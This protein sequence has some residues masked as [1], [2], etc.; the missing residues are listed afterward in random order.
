ML[1]T[2]LSG[3][4]YLAAQRVHRRDGRV[5][6]GDR[7]GQPHLARVSGAARRRQLEEAGEDENVGASVPGG[8]QPALLSLD[9]PRPRRRRCGSRVPVRSLG[10]SARRPSRGHEPPVWSRSMQWSLP[11]PPV[12]FRV[13]G[14]LRLKLCVHERAW[15]R[16]R[17]TRGFQ[18]RVR[19]KKIKGDHRETRNALFA[20]IHCVCGVLARCGCCCQRRAAR[21]H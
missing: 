6:I 16:P 8:G 17:R 19:S 11:A 21:E 9:E 18:A 14:G 15:E 7:K 13:Y 4:Q 20:A 2:I 12:L 5:D 10:R 3:S 1:G